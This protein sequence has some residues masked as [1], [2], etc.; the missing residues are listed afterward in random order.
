MWLKLSGVSMIKIGMMAVEGGP[1]NILGEDSIR[2]AKIALDE[3]NY[4][5]A[6]QPIELFI[7]GTNALA[8]SATDACQELVHGVGVDVVVGP[9]SGDEAVATR[10]FANK[11]PERVFVNGAAGSQQIYDPAE[12]FF[13]F[14]SNGVQFISGLGQHCYDSGF[15]RV[16]ILSEAYSFT[17]AQ[18][19]AFALEFCKAGG[20]IVDILWCPLG[21][22][23][24]RPYIQKMPPD[25]DAICSILGGTDSVRFIQQYRE[26][27]NT[28]PIIGGT[29][30]GDPT[31]LHFVQDYPNLLKGVLTA[32]PICDTAPDSNWQAFLQAYHALDD[33]T[34]LY[35]PSL[36]GTGYYM[37]MKALLQALEAID[38]DLSNNQS[39]LKDA[40]LNLE[41]DGLTCK[42]KLDRHRFPIID[43]FI[44]EITVDDNGRVH[45]RMVKRIE[46]VDS[47]LGYSDDEWL[48]LGRFSTQNI[49]CERFA[50][51]PMTFSEIIQNSRKNKK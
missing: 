28:T 2:C 21:T 22:P 25:I 34:R 27:S 39:K 35:S 20:T 48:A 47:T 33:D 7:Q 30:Q 45:T 41:L 49:P 24:F 6:G 14:W 4:T 50:N 19:G 3:V 51:K 5:I 13:S 17:F 40:L 44:N 18:V 26:E 11:H 15:K 37:N 42:V 31:T 12:N 1:Y 46:N 43:N 29:L 10:G 23:D 16:V 32:S 38:G 9:V 8:S 36:L